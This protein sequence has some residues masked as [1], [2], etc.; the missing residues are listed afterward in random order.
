MSIEDVI[1]IVKEASSLM[2]TDSFVVDEKDGCENIVTSS[3]LAVQHFLLSRLSELL[4]GSG[5]LCEE[6]DC[7]TEQR[8]YTWIID[9]IDGTANYAHFLPECSISV[10][11]AKGAEVIM[12]VVYCPRIGE[13]YTA[14]KGKGAFLNGRPIHVSSKAF[15]ESLICTAMS[16]YRK[17]F[18]QS[19]NDII[20]DV[21]MQ[22]N[23]YRR[24]GVASV[25]MCFIG[26]GRCDL[27]FEM[28]LMPWDY[29]AAGLV[30]TEAGGCI[31]NLNGEHPSL[32]EPDLVVGANTPEN[33]E[34]L[35]AIVRK[36]VPVRPY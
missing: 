35:L 33:L 24:F 27:Y 15:R 8:E 5:F 36:H 18:A 12:A 1:A 31:C 7:V 17:E 25:E 13:L 4:P 19:C 23:D 3:D 10:A 30:M 28:R 20:M 32:K 6:E 11:L 34:K 9:P 26:A 2:M 16:T 21:Y 22:S 29:A 14:E